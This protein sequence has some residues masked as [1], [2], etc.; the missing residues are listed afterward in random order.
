VEDIRFTRVTAGSAYCFDL[1]RRWMYGRPAGRRSHAR[2]EL[3]E[4]DLIESDDVRHPNPFRQQ[5]I[6]DDAAVAAPPNSF[7]THNGAAMATSERS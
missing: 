7:D 4:V 5:V 3:C 1:L 2:R 6:G